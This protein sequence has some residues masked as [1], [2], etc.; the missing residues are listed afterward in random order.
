MSSDGEASARRLLIV[1][2]AAA[3]SPDELPADVRR[4]IEAAEEVLVVSPVLESKLHLWMNDTDRGREQADERLAAVLEDV[5]A[6]RGEARGVV[7][8]EWPLQAFD[9]AIR[10]FG[11]DQ[12][13]IGLRAGTRAAWQEQ[14]LVDRVRAEFG[15]PVAVVEIDD[16]GRISGA[17]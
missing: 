5:Q 1:A 8:D 11:P 15:L 16:D 2:G 13:L 14:G 6:V 3:A 12:I 9:D 10:V 17:G 7:G 4:L